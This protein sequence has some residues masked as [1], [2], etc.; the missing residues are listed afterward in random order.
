[1]TDKQELPKY[2]CHKT[3][4]AMKIREVVKHAH[5][6]PNYDDAAFEASDKFEG[7]LLLP[8]DEQYSPVEV[9]A[10]WYRRHKPQPGGYYVVYEDGYTSYSPAKAFEDGYSPEDGDSIQIFSGKPSRIVL[11]DLRI[12]VQA[13][14][15]VNMEDLCDSINLYGKDE[16]ARR[17][18]VRLV[19]I[20]TRIPDLQG[21]QQP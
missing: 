21:S 20:L 17:L 9:S 4:R 2:R 10:E 12:A 18:G 3:V 7:A 13:S 6:D 15:A 19:E 8:E 14:I 11:S 5:P 16:T 1:M